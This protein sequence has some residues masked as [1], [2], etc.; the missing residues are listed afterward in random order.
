MSSLT[1]HNIPDETLRALQV[2]AEKAGCTL[3]AEVV[4]VIESVVRPS[5]RIKLGSLLA[6]IGQQA[7]GADLVFERDKSLAEPLDLNS[8][9]PT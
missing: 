6:E 2:R 8:P 4:A 5:D 3:E 1:V 7:N 9:P